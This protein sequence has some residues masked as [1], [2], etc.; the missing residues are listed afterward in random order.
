MPELQRELM[1]LGR[2]FNRLIV[3]PL[4]SVMRFALLKLRP[5]VSVGKWS[6]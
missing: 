2:A 1:P 4:T 3:A 5:T 6:S